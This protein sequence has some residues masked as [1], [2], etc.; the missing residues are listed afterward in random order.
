MCPH[1]LFLD[2]RKEI[3]YKTGGLFCKKLRE[4]V[5]KYDACRIR[6][7]GVGLGKEGKRIKSGK[8][9]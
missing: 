6:T 8:T 2:P 1:A 4:V 7:A 9:S 5:G 3:C